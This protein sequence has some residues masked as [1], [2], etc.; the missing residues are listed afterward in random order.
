MT[1]AADAEQ[2][3]VDAAEIG[4]QLVVAPARAGQI[5]GIG[6]RAEQALVREVD[7]VDELAR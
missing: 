1:V 3:H 6:T 5:L 7:V 4:D 2:L